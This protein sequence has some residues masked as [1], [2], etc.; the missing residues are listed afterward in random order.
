MSSKYG[1]KS[2]LDTIEDFE[3][4]ESVFNNEYD[5]HLARVINYVSAIA[6]D[7]HTLKLLADNNVLDV[8]DESPCKDTLVPTREELE[9]TKAANR[10]YL[11]NE[12]DQAILKK[13]SALNAN[14]QVQLEIDRLITDQS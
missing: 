12:I 10:R 5:Q 8:S 7:E 9:T 3:K 2:R 4:I 11:D 1:E 6:L 14:R 13:V